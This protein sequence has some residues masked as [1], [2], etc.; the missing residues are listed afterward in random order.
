MRE[1]SRWYG[2]ELVFKN[3]TSE[4]FHVE[5]SRD[6]P[7]SKVLRILE[8]TDKIHFGISGRTVTVMP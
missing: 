4:R 5:I 6:I 8:M 1:L 3:V 2:L 7:L